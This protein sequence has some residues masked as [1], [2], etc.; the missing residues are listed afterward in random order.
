MS[1][2]TLIRSIFIGLYF[3]LSAILVVAPEFLFSIDLNF[4]EASH[5]WIAGTGIILYA[6]DDYLSRWKSCAWSPSTLC[7]C[8]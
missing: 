6:I 4:S 1:F 2:S 8:R 3:T 7:P 5:L